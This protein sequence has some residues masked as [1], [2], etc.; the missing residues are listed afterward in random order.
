MEWN[1]SYFE[2][3]LFNLSNLEICWIQNRINNNDNSIV[4]IMITIGLD[5]IGN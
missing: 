3:S 1:E 5:P 4:L 2:K